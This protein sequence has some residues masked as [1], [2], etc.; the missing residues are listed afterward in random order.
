MLWWFLFGYAIGFITTTVVLYVYHKKQV[1][2]LRKTM[3]DVH[4]AYRKKHHL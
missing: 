1:Q 3:E 2:S 4:Y